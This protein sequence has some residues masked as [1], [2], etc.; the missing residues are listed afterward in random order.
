M[1][2]KYYQGFTLVELL[3]VIG[4]IAVLSTLVTVYLETARM[5][6]RDARRVS[7]VKQIQLALKMYYTDLGT[8]PTYVT[9]NANIVN[10]G[11]NYLSRVPSNP[12][13]R[14]DHGCPDIDY[15]YTQL[16]GGKRYSLTFCLGDKTDDLDS[17][18]HN[19]THNG[20]LN[21]PTGYV[22]VPGS[23][24]FNTNDFCVMKYEA[25]CAPG[26]DL[27]FG[28]KDP[29]TANQTYSTQNGMGICTGNITDV[30]RAVSIPSGWSMADVTFSQ[31]KDFCQRVGAHLITNAEW[32]TI[33]RN[34]ENVVSS[35]EYYSNWSTGTIGEGYMPEGIRGNDLA[36]EAIEEY[37]PLY[38]DHPSRRTLILSTGERIWDF[39]GNVSE[40]V[41]TTCDSQ[42]D[43]P[44][45]TV[46]WDYGD[47]ANY[48]LPMSGPSSTA[49]ASH[50]IGGYLGCTEIGNT[51]IRGGSATG[52]A[53]IYNLELDHGGAYINTLLGFRC[54]KN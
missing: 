41:D 32:M 37:F 46:T 40:W 48:E 4:V 12:T 3:V 8:Y 15:Q 23:S 47:L 5:S 27:T 13:P 7:D 53:G 20:I 16:E 39:A 19:V 45:S 43:N 24:A 52:D 1:K 30:G 44:G 2:N 34:S 28:M 54:V 10:G 33:A 22:A 35:D 49:F 6:A 17:G 11:T 42:Y 50:G 38:H 9:P 36:D 26:D 25:K 31:A 21:C 18:N 14:T 29:A 51:F